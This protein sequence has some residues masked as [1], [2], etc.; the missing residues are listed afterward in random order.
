M[1]GLCFNFKSA[2]CTPVVQTTFQEEDNLIFFRKR[3]TVI[4]FIDVIFVD[5]ITIVQTKFII[6]CHFYI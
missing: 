1:P 3:I 4:F 2:Q 6:I 5:V